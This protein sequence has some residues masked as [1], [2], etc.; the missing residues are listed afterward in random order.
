MRRQDDVNGSGHADGATLQHCSTAIASSS[1]SINVSDKY[2]LIMIQL[3]RTIGLRTYIRLWIL[4]LEIRVRSEFLIAQ[5]CSDSEG[6]NTF[7]N[8]EIV[9]VWSDL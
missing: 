4:L 7:F 8:S 9:Q 6:V 3:T 1:V 2:K 5:D